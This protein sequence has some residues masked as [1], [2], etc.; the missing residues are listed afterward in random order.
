MKRISMEERAMWLDDWKQSGKNAWQYAKENGLVPQ[1][2]LKW[3]KNQK[4]ESKEILVEVPKQLLHSIRHVHEILIEK[5]D[6]RIH[7]PLE[8]V[9]N[10]LP[11]IISKLGQTK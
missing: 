3:T 5:G 2:F 10:E 8:P 11:G 9:L 6:I 4:N 7:I 1:T